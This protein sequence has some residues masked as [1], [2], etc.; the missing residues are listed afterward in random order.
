MH[1]PDGAGHDDAHC[2]Q[3]DDGGH[4][5]R[6]PGFAL[7][8]KPPDV[9]EPGVLLLKTPGLDLL[10]HEGFHHPDTGKRI[11]DLLVDRR[12]LL[13]A[14][15]QRR[16]HAFVEIDG[17]DDRDR[18]DAE[19][20][21]RQRQVDERQ[22]GDCAHKLQDRDGD[23]FRPMVAKLTDIEE[24]VGDPAH[25]LPD[26]LSVV[27]AERQFLIVLEQ[28]AAHGAFHLRA[29]HMALIVDEERAERLNR[30]QGQHGGTGQIDLIQDSG[31]VA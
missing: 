14:Q 21:Q 1:H 23:I 29:H 28:L 4:A 27:K 10:T 17:V 25:K 16:S 11:L 12:D 24:V 19:D 7:V 13:F 22:Q 5:H 26:P 8:P 9:Q 18:E 15:P 30:Q 2:D 31:H 3:L 20:D 6:E